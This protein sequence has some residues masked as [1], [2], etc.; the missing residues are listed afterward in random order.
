M[1]KT[2]LM[3]ALIMLAGMNITH[4]GEIKYIMQ[5][6]GAA[7]ASCA[8]GL[9]KKFRK[10]DGVKTFDIDLK[11]GKVSV[12][13]DEKLTLEDEQLTQLFIESGYSY[14]GKTIEASCDSD[15]KVT[16]ASTETKT[17]LSKGENVTL[18]GLFDGI[19]DDGKDFYLVYKSEVIEIIPPKG[20]MPSN[21]AIGTPLSIRGVVIGEGEGGEVKIQASAIDEPTH[22][23]N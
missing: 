10:I 12:C 14:K 22:D 8:Y 16:A 7:C 9:E 23:E 4:A 17:G 5:I 19:C 15:S 13:A 2:M 3:S 6:H 1:R 20:K 11:E 21:I 18:T